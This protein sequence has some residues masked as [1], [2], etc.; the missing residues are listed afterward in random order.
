MY[1]YMRKYP[2]L[3]HS[4][5]LKIKELRENK[6][7]F[8]KIQSDYY[9][10]H[11]VDSIVSLC[12]KHRIVKHREFWSEEE[13]LVLKTEAEKGTAFDKITAMLP[14]RNYDTVVKYASNH[15]MR[16]FRTDGKRQY[17]S[18]GKFWNAPNPINSYWAGFMAADGNVTLDNK[19]LTL[20]ITLQNNDEETLK[21]FLRCSSSDYPI[22]T[23]KLKNSKLKSEKLYSQVCIRSLDWFDSELM[24]D[25]GVVPRKTKVLKAPNISDE[26]FEYYMAGFIDGDGGYC[27]SDGQLMIQVCGFVPDILEKIRD[28]SLRFKQKARRKTRKVTFRSNTH[29]GIYKISIKGYPAAHMAHHLMSLPCHHL[30]RKYLYVKDFLDRNPKFNLSLPPYEEKLAQLA[31]TR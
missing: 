30:E 24:K 27:V 1:G 22:R 28:F 10:S 23:F 11:S 19:S 15:N 20:S 13:I 26:L 17:T 18:D 8:N 31:T 4:D 29:N 9:P 3:L 25:F 2:E 14:K 5:L 7:T 12:K 16:N 21:N 6:I